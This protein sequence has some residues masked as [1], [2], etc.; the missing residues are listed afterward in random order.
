MHELR[1]SED[2]AAIVLETAISKDLSRVTSVNIIFGEMIQIVPDIFRS[3][4][5]ESVRDTMAEGAELNIE[6]T[7]VKMKCIRC[8]TEFRVRDNSYACSICGST[9]LDIIQ[10]KELFVKS[11]EGE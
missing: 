11:I 6:I 8:G 3:A 1:I 4:F 10:G 2:L 5:Q 9:G 7:P